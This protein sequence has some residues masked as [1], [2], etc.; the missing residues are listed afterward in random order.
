MLPE[1]NGKTLIVFSLLWMTSG[2]P[3][4]PYEGWSS[5]ERKKEK[6]DWQGS[7]NEVKIKKQLL[8][9]SQFNFAAQK[10]VYFYH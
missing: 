9:I 7:T 6:T 4:A 5:L 8:L 1:V 10:K 3:F 2:A